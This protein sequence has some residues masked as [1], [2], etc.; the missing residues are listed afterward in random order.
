[1]ARVDGHR[2]AHHGVHEGRVGSLQE[3]QLHVVMAQHELPRRVGGLDD[4]RPERHVEQLAQGDVGPE[5]RVVKVLHGHQ[6]LHRVR[7]HLV[8]GHA[9]VGFLDRLQ[10]CG[11]GLWVLVEK[12]RELDGILELHGLEEPVVILVQ[13]LEGVVGLQG[14]QGFPQPG[15]DAD[16]ALQVH[17]LVL[18]FI[19]RPEGRHRRLVV[20]LH[21]EVE[22][23]QRDGDVL[24]GRVQGLPRLHPG[25]PSHIE[26]GHGE[27]PDHERED[28]GTAE[29]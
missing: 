21:A 12:C 26:G 25:D 18:V 14:G 15:D 9:V 8:P 4:G 29:S 6:E 17:E 19:H 11:D 23:L 24:E 7:L 3:D 10:L 28:N 20:F 22:V 13:A 1:M 27:D 16:E 2:D 5:K